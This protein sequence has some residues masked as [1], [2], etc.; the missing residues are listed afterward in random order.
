MDAIKA[1]ETRKS[2]RSYVG[3]PIEQEKV[4]VLAMAAN[5]A[6]KS[7]S[8]HV[9]IITNSDTLTDINDKA[10]EAMK[11]SGNDFLMQRA[12]LPGYQPMYG[13]PLL[14]I[15]SGPDTGSAAS[16]SCSATAITIA[17]TALGLGSCYVVTPTLPLKADP[18]L[19]TR[20]GIPQGNI[21]LCGVLAGYAQG[22]A[23]ASSNHC[24]TDNITYCY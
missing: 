5:S 3:T 4:K 14:M 22:D 23:F 16:A 15:L 6:P 17:A 13:A 18:G 1:I 10:L 2:T 24:V 19:A 20:A 9:T 12:A 21:P 7:G 11:N 8:F